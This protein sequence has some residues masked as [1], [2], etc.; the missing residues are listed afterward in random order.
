MRVL[1]LTPEFQ[2]QRRLYAGH[3]SPED[4]RMRTVLR[5]L[6]DERAPLPGP[7]DSEILRTPHGRIWG[8]SVPGTDLM[9]TYVIGTSSIDVVGV[10]PAW[11]EVR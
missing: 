5:Q 6:I 8:R 7:E 11:R 10:H 3:G 4:A 1:V 9:L 2:R